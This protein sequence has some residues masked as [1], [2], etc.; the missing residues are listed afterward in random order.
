ML[1]RKLSRY[2]IRQ[3]TSLRKGTKRSEE[4]EVWTIHSLYIQ[5]CNRGATTSRNAKLCDY[6]LKMPRPPNG[7]AVCSV[8]T[9]KIPDQATL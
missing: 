8:Q 6:K 5:Y 4:T 2:L 1:T 7:E 3:N 9:S